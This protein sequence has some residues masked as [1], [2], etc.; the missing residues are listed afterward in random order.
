MKRSF[1]IL[2][3]AILAIGYTDTFA[4]QSININTF[5]IAKDERNVKNFNGIAAG[6]PIDVIVKIGDKESL[7]FEG[8]EEAIATLISEVKGNIL[9]IRPQNS[10]KSW[11]KKYE[12]KKITAHVTAKQIS[13]LAMSGNGT[14]NISG[15][16]TASEFAVTLSGSG[17]IKANVDADKITGVL[18]GS[19]SIVLSGKADDASVTLSGSGS[20]GSKTLAV[21]NLSARVSGSGNININTDG[22]IKAVISGSGHV[23]YSGNPEI[24]ETVLLGSGRVSKR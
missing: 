2:L 18:S 4:D 3:V 7:T 1:S 6:G 11:A 10:W 14:I 17:S 23:Y 24:N 16:A 22:N 5:H 9:I 19:G 13:S 12:N 20:F 21:N 15:T 8:D